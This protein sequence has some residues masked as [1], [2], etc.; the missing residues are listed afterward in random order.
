[1]MSGIR[2]KNTQPE[3][4]VRRGLHAQGFRFRTHVST[5]P[6]KPD[7]VLRRFRTAVFV[8][9]CFWHGH[10]C[11]LFKMPKSRTDFWRAKILGNQ[12]RDT[13]AVAALREQGWRVLVVWE[14]ALK[15]AGDRENKR[16]I[17]IAA[18]WIKGRATFGEIARRNS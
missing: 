9:G 10:S 13:R 17:S 11:A 7:L 14:C 5:L 16:T 15:S 3:L 1:M 18:S 8:H 4:L 12:S 6:G 2:A